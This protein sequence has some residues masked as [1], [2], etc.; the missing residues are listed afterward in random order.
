MEKALVIGA[1]GGI[2]QALV[3]ELAQRYEVTALSRS[4]DGLDV[5]DEASVSA[6]LGALEGPFARIIVATGALEIDGHQ[7][8]R[9]IKALEP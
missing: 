4:K 5:T 2:G 9:T 3:A 8:E 6:A 1:S 7:P